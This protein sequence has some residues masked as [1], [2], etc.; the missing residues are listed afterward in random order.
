M[1]SPESPPT[2]PRPVII[3][4]APRIPSPPPSPPRPAPHKPRTPS[5]VSSTSSSSSSS[6]TSSSLAPSSIPYSSHDST[7]SD[8]KWFSPRS[9]GQVE[10]HNP[11]DLELILRQVQRRRSSATTAGLSTL[12]SPY[13]PAGGT[14]TLSIGEVPPNFPMGAMF[15]QQTNG[16]TTPSGSDESSHS[17]GSE[18][19]V[20]KN[21]GN[22]H[23]PGPIH[24]KYP[25]STGFLDRNKHRKK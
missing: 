13:S 7:L 24:I 23:Q 25:R 4:P 5:P 18:G 19:Q 21:G 9:N 1:T 10:P 11:A 20:T 16:H 15:A 8:H 2:P 12:S 22:H 17:G 3:P 6:L 14:H